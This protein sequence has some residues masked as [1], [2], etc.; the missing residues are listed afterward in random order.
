MLHK[1]RIKL[2][3]DNLQ[4]GHPWG[5]VFLRQ[6]HKCTRHC[7]IVSRS[8]HRATRQL[9]LFHIEDYLSMIVLWCPFIYVICVYS[10]YSTRMIKCIAQS[11]N[12]Y[13]HGTCIHKIKQRFASQPLFPFLNLQF[14]FPWPCA[15]SVLYTINQFECRVLKHART[16]S[17]L[18]NY[19]TLAPIIFNDQLT[20]VRWHY[21][22][23][24]RCSVNCHRV[25]T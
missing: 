4:I 15:D 10:M 19:K 9:I 16:V 5:A 23:Q 18:W 20:I 8:I 2:T 25:G 17:E 3:T 13:M 7:S 22:F 12:I 14:M 6:L 11:M 1:P 24:F 21:Y